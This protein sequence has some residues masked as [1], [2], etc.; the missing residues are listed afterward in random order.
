VEHAVNES[1]SFKYIVR[2]GWRWRRRLVTPV[3]ILTALF[4]WQWSGKLEDQLGKA[5]PLVDCRACAR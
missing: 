4:A 5:D 1:N 3:L 2:K